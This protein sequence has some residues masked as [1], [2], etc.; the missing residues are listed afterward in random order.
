[1]KGQVLKNIEIDF[2][3]YDFIQFKYGGSMREISGIKSEF[4]NYID[5][6]EDD[7]SRQDVL[8]MYMLEDMAFHFVEDT[9]K[10]IGDLLV[11]SDIVD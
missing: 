9:F 3:D 1:M 11:R 6:F 5:N 4:L 10:T 2:A 7:W 8:D